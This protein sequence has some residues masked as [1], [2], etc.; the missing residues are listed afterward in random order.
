[1]TLFDRIQE[2]KEALQ[3]KLVK[4]TKIGI[5]LGTGL[6]GLGEKIEESQVVSYRDIPHFPQPTGM[7]HKAEVYCGY[8]GGKPVIAFGGR[9][10]LYEGYNEESITLPVRVAKALGVEI[11]IISNAAGGLNPLF[12]TPDIMIIDDHINFTGR[13]PLIGPNDDRLGPRFPDM[14]APYDQELIQRMEQVALQEKIK[15][16]RGVYIGVT[17]PNLE[18]RAEYR[19]FRQ[20]GADAVGMSTVLEVIAGV[21]VGLRILG[22]SVITDLC[23]PDALKPVNIEEILQNA[24]AGEKLL[25]KLLQAFLRSLP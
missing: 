2:A 20:W 7:E 16:H 23:F 17:G 4:G 18:T 14:S 11:L 24:S 1:M 12:R 25:T 3:P 21:H 19:A 15:V 22:L 5:V 8:L 13:N 6:S 10:H 9:F